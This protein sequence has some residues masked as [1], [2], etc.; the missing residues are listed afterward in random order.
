MFQH[1]F[2]LQMKTIIGKK[3]AKISQH[4]N[5]NFFYMLVHYTNIKILNNII[6][7]KS[8][9]KSTLIWVVGKIISEFLWVLTK[10][11][12]N[13]K[14]IK[15]RYIDIKVQNFVDVNFYWFVAI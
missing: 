6:N 2:S 12:K 5:I 14:R 15:K 13:K 10:M 3:L 7:I 11:Q 9:A 4:I 8:I 1:A